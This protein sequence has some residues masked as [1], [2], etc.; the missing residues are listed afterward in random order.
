MTVDRSAQGPEMLPNGSEFRD[1]ARSALNGAC[2]ISGDPC[3][4]NE[5]VTLTMCRGAENE[6]F[7]DGNGGV[8]EDY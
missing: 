6:E 7:C 4:W 2:S 1:L 5:S 8:A 3:A